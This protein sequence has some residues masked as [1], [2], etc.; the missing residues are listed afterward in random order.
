M[1]LFNVKDPRWLRNSWPARTL[2]H[3]TQQFVSQPD[4]K[5]FWRHLCPWT[6]VY[7]ACRANDR[8]HLAYPLQDGFWALQLAHVT[9]KLAALSPHRYDFMPRGKLR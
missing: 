2:I 8:V 6:E 1:P 7:P 9:L 4:I 5:L 3:Q